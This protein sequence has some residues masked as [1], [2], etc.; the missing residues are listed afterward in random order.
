MVEFKL[1]T[2]I[3]I[4]TTAA[5]PI[6]APTLYF[7]GREAIR[8]TNFFICDSNDGPKV[9]LAPHSLQNTA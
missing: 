1:A 7:L 6:P 8:F 9:S 4:T 5:I 3:R 2:T